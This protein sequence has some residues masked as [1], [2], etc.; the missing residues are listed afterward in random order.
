MLIHVSLGDNPLPRLGDHPLPA[1][2]QVV[3]FLLNEFLVV[4]AYQRIRF[5]LIDQKLRLI[6]KKFGVINGIADLPPDISIRLGVFYV[7]RTIRGYKFVVL[8]N[9]GVIAPDPADFPFAIP[10]IGKIQISI[11]KKNSMQNCVAF[12][13]SAMDAAVALICVRASQPFLI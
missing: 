3:Q 2:D 13:I 10:L 11:M 5:Q 8:A 9:T 4:P 6:Q 1:H 7:T 12:L